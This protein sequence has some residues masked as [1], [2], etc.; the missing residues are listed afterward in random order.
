[1]CRFKK[2]TEKD[3]QI[4][5]KKLFSR[6][7]VQDLKL[8]ISLYYNTTSIAPYNTVYNFSCPNNPGVEKQNNTQK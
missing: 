7:P 8:T 3:A 2:I 6:D 5:R 4:F 1:M